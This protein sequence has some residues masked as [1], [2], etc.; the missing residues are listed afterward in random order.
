MPTDR[1]QPVHLQHWLSGSSGLLRRGRA[2]RGAGLLGSLG[3]S[4]G[5]GLEVGFSDFD[6]LLGRLLHR[7]VGVVGSG[8]RRLH[9]GHG[10]LRTGRGVLGEVLDQCLHVLRAFGQLG[11]GH[12]GEFALGFRSDLV[13]VTGV[14][15][16]LFGDR[17]HGCGL[18][19]Q[20]FLR[21]LGRQRF[22]G[23]FHVFGEGGLDD[24]QVQFDKLFD[25]FKRLG[26]QAEQRF[27]V[28]L[29]CCCDL[30]RG[31]DH[32][33]SPVVNFK[34][35]QIKPPRC[36]GRDGVSPVSASPGVWVSQG[37]NSFVRRNKPYFRGGQTNVKEILCVAQ[38]PARPGF[39]QVTS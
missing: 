30:F 18:E 13:Q 9:D 14:G 39:L 23:V 12:L 36:Q 32:C 24:L 15:Q 27:E 31:E 29:L 5:S 7:L 35:K 21:I 3:G 26:G 22:L 2:G 33:W 20:Q 34:V 17:L 37:A 19:G 4:R 10:R 1:P 25:A 38:N 6:R 16:G 8:D 11:L 28:S